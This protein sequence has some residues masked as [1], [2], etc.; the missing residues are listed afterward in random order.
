MS[1]RDRFRWAATG[2]SQAMTGRRPGVELVRVD[3]PEL[4]LPQPPSLALPAPEHP[5]CRICGY[6]HPRGGRW[7]HDEAGLSP[8]A[9]QI[10]P[11][12]GVSSR[13][14]PLS[15]SRDADVSSLSRDR[16]D[17]WR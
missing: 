12:P 14:Q 7:R 8:Y 2:I 10:A 3:Q 6:R 4:D 11:E 13:P 17:P 1:L 5:L 9:R 16:F 15:Q